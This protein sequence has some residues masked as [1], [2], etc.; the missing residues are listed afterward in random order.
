M[1]TYS[2]QIEN[3]NDRILSIAVNIL[4]E[5]GA[6]TKVISTSKSKKEKFYNIEESKIFKDFQKWKKENPIEAEQIKKELNE[7]MM[8]YALGQISRSS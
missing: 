1:K 5:L 6:K 7:E 8:I 2:I 3:A 4:E